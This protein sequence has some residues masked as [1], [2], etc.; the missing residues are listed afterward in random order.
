M[1]MSGFSKMVPQHTHHLKQWIVGKPCS[2]DVSFYV[3][4]TLPGQPSLQTPLCLTALSG[5]IC[6]PTNKPCMLTQLKEHIRDEIRATVECL[7]QTVYG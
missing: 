4:V 3:A 2:M 5:D 6:N 1:V 7:L